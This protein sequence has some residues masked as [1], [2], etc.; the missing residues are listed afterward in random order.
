MEP[1]V[2]PRGTR[3]GGHAPP[4]PDRCRGAEPDG[5]GDHARDLPAAHRCWRTADRDR[6]GDGGTGQGRGQRVPRRQGVVHQR[7]VR[8]L[9]RHRSVRG[10]AGRRAG[11]GRPHRARVP[12]RWPR[13]RRRLPAQGRPRA[14]RLRR[15][16][17]QSGR[18]R[19]QPAHGARR[20]QLRPPPAGRGPR[21]DP[22]RRAARQA[23]RA[24]GRGVQARHRRRAR[25]AWPRRRRPALPPR[26]GGRGVRPAG[27]GQRAGGVPA[28]RLR[29][30]RGGGRAPGRRGARGHRL[31]GVRGARP[32]RDYG[33]CPRPP[34]HRRMPGCR[35]GAMARSGLDGRRP[36]P[37]VT[38]EGSRCDIVHPLTWTM[39]HRARWCGVRVRRADADVSR[40]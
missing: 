9:R 31:A 36:L 11:H 15:Q 12:H 29:G 10:H 19:R 35:P 2:P 26:R 30:Q 21:A 6:R 40:R 39:S 16:H 7:D 24:V 14:A 23:D 28:P 1:G 5:R 13:L 38:P 20:D 18:R 34:A 33:G 22:A 3:G 17:R 37:D 32:G 25:F 4:G 27:H 8:H